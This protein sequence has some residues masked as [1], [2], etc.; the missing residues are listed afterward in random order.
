M[1]TILH[2]G[3]TLGLRLRP[4]GG[5][6]TGSG[7]VRR[8]LTSPDETV[9]TGKSSKKLY[10]GEERL[11][12]EGKGRP[13]LPHSSKCRAKSGSDL[14]PVSNPGWQLC[15]G[16]GASVPLVQKHYAGEVPLM[17]DGSTWVGTKIMALSK[18][19]SWTAMCRCPPFHSPQARKGR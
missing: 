16:R 18:T 13:D 10:L 7:A 8:G 11:P 1:N 6:V 4:N 17:P 19:T 3:S 2:M 9:E 5:T 12:G 14:D 15:Q